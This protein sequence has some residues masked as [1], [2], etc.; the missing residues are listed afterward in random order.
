M[1]MYIVTETMRINRYTINANVKYYKALENNN[2]YRDEK[3]GKQRVRN[4][5]RK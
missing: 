3:F 2:L 5:L 1:E 4:I